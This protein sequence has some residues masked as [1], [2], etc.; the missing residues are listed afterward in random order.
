MPGL[1]LDYA[2]EE[3]TLGFVSDDPWNKA[4]I[5]KVDGVPAAWPAAPVIEFADATVTD[6]V[7]VVSDY[8]DD[9][10]VVHT[11]AKATWTK[12]AAEVNTL[13]DAEDKKIRFVVSGVT[14]FAGRA[15]KRA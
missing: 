10:A 13:A 12:T 6:W 15:I 5:Y 1:T 3:F 7:A 14:W 2:P 11:N 9:E 4:L 8:V